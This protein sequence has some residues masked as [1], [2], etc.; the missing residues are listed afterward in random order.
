MRH[1]AGHDRT[2]LPSIAFVLGCQSVEGSEYLAWVA[3]D[4][5][6]GVESRCL[7]GLEDPVRMKGSL[8]QIR[9]GGWVEY[10]TLELH[11][12]EDLRLR[13]MEQQGTLVPTDSEGLVL[14][15]MWGHLADVR[16]AIAGTGL[17]AENLPPVEIAYAPTL[18]DPLAELFPFENAA[19]IPGAHVLVVLPEFWDQGLPLAANRG[20]IA[21]EWG[22]AVFHE[23]LNGEA[24]A[25][26]I[27]FEEGAGEGNFYL[28][29]M[30]EGFADVLAAL[31]FD[32][33]RFLD[34][35]IDMPARWVDTARSL[36]DVETP[37]QFIDSSALGIFYDPYPLGSV[38]A[39]WY[40]SLSQGL[41]DPDEALRL[42]E[43]GALALGEELARA[44]GWGEDLRWLML[45]G[46][47]EAADGSV[48]D[49]GCALAEERLIGVELRPCMP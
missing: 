10:D 9:S 37:E 21:H 12:G 16:A 25:R 34:A 22:H 40:W 17:R 47:L 35:S 39:S 43:S 42:L 14:V 2:L 27:Q 36:A 46:T 26:P 48:R 5:G 33:P 3:E 31:L 44:D 15:S 6:Y 20:V 8:G 32:D 23:L 41:S 49:R 28:A 7:P 19:Y 4:G 1:R 38:V 13:F 18:P 29:A 11:P 24:S 45:E 30:H